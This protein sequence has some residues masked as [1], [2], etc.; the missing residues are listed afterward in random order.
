MNQTASNTYSHGYRWLAPMLSAGPGAD[1]LVSRND[2]L[3]IQGGDGVEAGDPRFAAPSA[4][5]ADAP[6]IAAGAA[7]SS[8]SGGEFAGGHV[9]T[10]PRSPFLHP[11]RMVVNLVV[12][13]RTHMLGAWLISW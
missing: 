7:P 13:V 12:T 4:P 3:W 2:D 6:V 8:P 9:A 11:R 5:V 1:A 10:A